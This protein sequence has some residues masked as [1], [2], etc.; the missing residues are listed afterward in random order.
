MYTQSLYL[1]SVYYVV[2]VAMVRE[3]RAIRV[4]EE[5]YTHL[6][7]MQALLQLSYGRRYS[8]DDVIRW[9]ISN[10]PMLK[11]ELPEEIQVLEG[12]EEEES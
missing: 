3:S 5:V 1:Y 7:R 10:A 12:G 2:L 4:S 8:I 11:V 9:L 6:V